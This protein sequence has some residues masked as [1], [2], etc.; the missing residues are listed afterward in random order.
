M[1]F[2]RLSSAAIIN[3]RRNIVA[4]SIGA[5]AEYFL[6]FLH[7]NLEMKTSMHPCLIELKLFAAISLRQ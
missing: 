4:V 7:G 1:L 2:D 5:R 3:A 6:L